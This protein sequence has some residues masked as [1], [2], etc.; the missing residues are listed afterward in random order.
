MKV[1]ILAAGYATRLYPLTLYTPKP[2]L[3]VAGKPLVEHILEKVA[4]LPVDEIFIVTNA[5]FYPHFC[6]WKEHYSSLPVVLVNDSTT[7]NDNRL[8][9][10]GDICYVC[11]QYGLDDDIMVLA[12]DNL[13]SFSLQEMYALFTI[14]R[15]S[16]VALYDV[17]DSVLAQQYGIV[18]ID[19]NARIV[20][21][22]EK[23]LKP[24]STLASTCMYVFP[25]EV[26][27]H[28]AYFTKKF[29]TDRTGD[30]LTWLYGR[31]TVLGYVTEKPW[32]DIGTI[33]QLE[34]ARK[35]W[36]KL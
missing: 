29:T 12:G 34:K 14:H 20:H 35:E 11:E 15:K 27:H 24:R 3:D 8:G 19:D 21:C 28:L 1:I 6:I 16:V 36:G 7:S 17:H 23:P 2:L 18:A 30:F 32:F 26:L 5:Q 33:E 9:S 25:R 22:E 4:E 10:L 13:F 31:E